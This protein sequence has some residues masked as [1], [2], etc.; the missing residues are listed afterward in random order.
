MD[1]NWN[2]R[3]IIQMC[4]RWL[5]CIYRGIK[6]KRQVVMVVM[7]VVVYLIWKNRNS[8]YWDNVISIIAYIV[9]EVKYIVKN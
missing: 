6:F 1:I 9:E 7:V 4:I 2:G 5:K 3:G 8:A